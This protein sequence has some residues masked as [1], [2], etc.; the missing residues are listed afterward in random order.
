MAKFVEVKEKSGD[1]EQKIKDALQF[2]KDTPAYVGVPENKTVRRKEDGEK[3]AITNAELMFIHT[4][5]SPRNNIPARPVIEPAIEDDKERISKMFKDAGQTMMNQ[6]KDAAMKKLKLIGM[7]AQNVCRAWFVNPKNN[8]PTN[9]PAT[10]AAKRAKGA[11][12]RPLIDTGQL[13]RSIIYFVETK[14]GRET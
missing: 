8:W 7:R 14:G 6:G 1:A 11:K 13:R 2:L 4:N 12:P 9:S 3:V 5:G 10:I